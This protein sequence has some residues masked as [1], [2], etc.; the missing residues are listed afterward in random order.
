MT[1]FQVYSLYVSIKSHFTGKYDYFKYNKKMRVKVETY[2]KR[3]DKYF[4]EKLSKKFNNLSDAENFFC[5]NMIYNPNVWIGNYLESSCED[6]YT[7]WIKKQQSFD[8]IFNNECLVLSQEK[9]I[10]YSKNKQY[11]KIL[12]MVFQNEV[13]IETLIILDKK[14]N[15]F[16]YWDK[17]FDDVIWKEFSNRIK[18]YSPFLKLDQDKYLKLIDHYFKES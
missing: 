2:N 17:N 14:F 13:S 12:T 4:F 10:F 8:Y 11:P 6:V 15:L 9:E 7:E 5:S 16:E 18:K 3:K 1:G